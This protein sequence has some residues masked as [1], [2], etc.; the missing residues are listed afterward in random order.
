MKRPRP[1]AHYPAF[2]NICGKRCVVIGGGVVALRKAEALLDFG[3]NVTV[4][5]PTLRPDLERL[6]EHSGN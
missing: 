1:S 3:A 6:A 4:V 2:L 5:S